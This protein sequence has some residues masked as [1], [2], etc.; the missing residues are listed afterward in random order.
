MDNSC[1]NNTN[2]GGS[3][4]SQMKSG[5]NSNSNTLQRQKVLKQLSH[6]LSLGLRHKAIEYQWNISNDGYVPI[7]EI[8]HHSM[9]GKYTIE[10]I[11]EVVQT[12]DKQRYSIAEFPSSKYS[13]SS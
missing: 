5:S 4:S 1:S 6:K 8:L 7:Q 9:F 12:N 11:I 13:I 10:D 2:T 3:S